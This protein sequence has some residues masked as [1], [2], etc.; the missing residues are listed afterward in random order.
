LLAFR[1]AAG[2]TQH[3]LAELLGVAHTSIAFWEWSE[4]PPRG[5]V[6]P[7]MAKA[8]GVTVEEILGIPPGSGSRRRSGPV[9]KLERVLLE[10]RT[11]PRR[12]Q[13]IVVKFV[14]TLLEQHKKAS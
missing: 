14:T 11:L 8:L 3:G 9:G 12:D 6:L 1:K 13:D 7:N 5:D 10:A 4:K 2:L